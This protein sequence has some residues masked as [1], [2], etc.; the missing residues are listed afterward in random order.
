MTAEEIL[1]VA[2]SIGWDIKEKE[3]KSA[4]VFLEKMKMIKIDKQ[5]V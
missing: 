4:I 3:A 2:E 1:D 5:R